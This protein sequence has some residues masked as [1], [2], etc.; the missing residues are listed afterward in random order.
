MNAAKFPLLQ[1]NR[2]LLR[3]FTDD[4]L[5]NV[6]LGLSHRDVIQY[7]GVSYT[8]LEETRSQ[9]KFFAG[10]EA[11]GTGS[12]WAVCSAVDGVFYGGCGLNNLDKEHQKAEIGFWLL[13]Q[14]WGKGIISAAVSL[15]C[16]YGF[17]VFHLNRIEAIIESE[18]INSK[19]VMERMKFNYE[20]TMKECEFKNGRFISLDFYA[21]LRSSIIQ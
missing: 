14:F 3:Q 12:W 21:S 4:D 18:N 2:L 17:T 13:P 9:M 1:T 16:N 15:V 20:G 10:L 19:K 5:E 7:Y 11:S 6:F 8:T